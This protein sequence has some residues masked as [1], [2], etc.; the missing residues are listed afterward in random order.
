MSYLGDLRKNVGNRPLFS[1]GA[2]I[3]VFNENKELY[4]WQ[5]VLLEIYTLATAKVS[6]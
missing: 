5:K 6:N 4:F 1:A 2:T 3:L